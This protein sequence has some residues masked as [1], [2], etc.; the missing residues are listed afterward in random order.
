MRGSK[1]L[2]GRMVWSVFLSVAACVASGTALA[3]CTPPLPLSTTNPIPCFIMVQPIDVCA[4]DGSSCS[5]FNTTST[6]GVG[7]PTTAC[8]PTG[9]NPLNCGNP[10]GFVVNP[11]TGAANPT[12]GGVDVT[13]TLLNQIGVDLLWLPMAPY[14]SQVKADGTTFQTLSVTQTTNSETGATT[15]DSTDFRLLTFQPEF[16]M[17]S[18]T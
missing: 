13:R 2:P 12:S 9:S 7:N 3:Q 17:G 15:F 6:T 4:P 8:D 14:S 10:I 5:P 16:K 1:S 11:T 18:P